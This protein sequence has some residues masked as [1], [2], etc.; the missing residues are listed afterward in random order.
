MPDKPNN[1][2]QFWQE[3]KRRKVIRVIPVYAAVAFGLL[4]LAD[5]TSGP[6]NFPGWVITFVMS[7]AAIGFPIAFLLL[8]LF[9]ATPGGIK[10]VHIDEETS[11]KISGNIMKT[12]TKIKEG[13]QKRDE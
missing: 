4:E 6:L 13:I 8:W 5:I 10:L 12:T 9:K 3:L 7:S 1:P 2:F 11:R